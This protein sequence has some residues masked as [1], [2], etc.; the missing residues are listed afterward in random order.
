MKPTL[1]LL[2]KRAQHLRL[3]KELR[4]HSRGNVPPTAKRWARQ[5]MREQALLWRCPNHCFA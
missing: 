3:A 1:T 4:D 2:Q 5:L